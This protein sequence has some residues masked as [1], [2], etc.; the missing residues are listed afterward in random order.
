[1]LWIIAGESNSVSV[2]IDYPVDNLIQF[3]ECPCRFRCLWFVSK[4]DLVVGGHSGVRK[5]FMCPGHFVVNSRQFRN[6]WLKLLKLDY[7]ED[8]IFDFLNFVLIEQRLI[9]TLVLF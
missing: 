1:M 5:R 3:V 8:V 7:R 9:K 6:V 2:G 4:V